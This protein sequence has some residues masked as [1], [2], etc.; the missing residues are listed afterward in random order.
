MRTRYEITWVLTMLLAGSAFGQ[1]PMSDPDA[2]SEAAGFFEGSTDVGRIA[3]PG[4]FSYDP[5]QQAYVVEGSGQNMWADRDDFYFV[6]RRLSGDFILR[7]RAE[8]KGEGVHPHRKMGWTVRVG[9]E[10]SSPHISLAVHGDGLTALQYR[11]NSGAETEEVRSSVTSPDVLQLARRGNTFT[12]SVARF[13]EV[14]TS[15]Q[16]TG[17]DLGDAVFVGLFVCSHDENVNERA[18]FGNVRIVMPAPDDLVAYQDYIGSRLEILTVE[19][20]HRRMIHST[21]D[22]MQAPNWTPDGKTLIFNRNG[23]LYRFD[24]LDQRVTELE[25]GFA[26]NNNNDHVLSFDGTQ[27]GISHHPPEHDNASIVYTLPATGGTPKQVTPRGPSYLHGWSPDAKYLIYTADRDGDYDIY[28]IPAGGGEEVRLTD[29][30]GLDDGSE[31]SPDGRYIYF[32]SV[33]SGSMEIWRMGPNGEHPEQLTDDAFNNW[34][35]HVSPDGRSVAFLSYSKDVDPGDHPFYKEVYL[36]LM[37]ADGGEPRVIAYL[38]GGQGT[39]NVPSWA[40]D[41]RR[42]AFVSNSASLED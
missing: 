40:P 15:E 10:P 11:R 22:S 23:L 36:R 4:S 17:L 30:P 1:V 9:L 16:V 37:S 20:G 28:R 12:M 33:R 19:S 21:T 42:L 38:Y 35:P 3:R 8:F 39:I 18:V 31:Y 6:W 29:S 5:E 2:S 34:F 41:S 25:T 32:N 7:T 26:T 14:F 13:G 24:L 27:L